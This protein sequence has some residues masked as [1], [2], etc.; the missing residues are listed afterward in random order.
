MVQEELEVLHLHL[1]NTCRRLAPMW[2]GRGT[3]AHLLIVLL[4]GSSKFKCPQGLIPLDQYSN[5]EPLL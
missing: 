5:S 3:K 4:P 1:K 2:L